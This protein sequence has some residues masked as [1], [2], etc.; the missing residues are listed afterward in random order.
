[1]TCT[2]SDRPA[3]AALSHSR[4]NA[5]GTKQLIDGHISFNLLKMA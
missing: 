5:Q 1:M 3:L 4:Q 2:T